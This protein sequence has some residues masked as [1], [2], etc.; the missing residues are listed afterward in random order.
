M[1]L[2]TSSKPDGNKDNDRVGIF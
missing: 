1:V 2:T